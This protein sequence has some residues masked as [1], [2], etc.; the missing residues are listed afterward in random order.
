MK[1]EGFKKDRYFHF[2]HLVLAES[3]VIYDEE[4]GF[5]EDMYFDFSQLV[6]V[7]SSKIYDEEEGLRESTMKREASERTGI[8]S[9]HMESSVSE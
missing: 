8:S 3:S 5:R 7:K 2:S 9:S 4:G 1:R 6:F